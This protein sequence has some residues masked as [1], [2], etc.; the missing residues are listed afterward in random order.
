MAKRF[1]DT[2]IFKKQFIRTLKA[3]YKVLWIY[4]LTDCNHSG[5]WEADF[6][7]AQLRL[8]VKVTKQEAE[9]VFGDKIIVLDNGGKWFIPSFIDF[10]YGKLSA[11]NRAHNSVILLLTKYNLLDEDLSIKE[12]TKPLTSPLQGDM[13][14]DKEKEKDKDKEKDK[15]ITQPKIEKSELELAFDNWVQMRKK[16]KSGITEH[17]IQLGKEEL[18]KL[19][20]GKSETAIAI[21][22]QSILNSWK[23]FF[24]LKTQNNVSTTNRNELDQLLEQSIDTLQ[25]P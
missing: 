24:P 5:I 9:Q 7:V 2:D 21:I 20:G 8:G 17:A 23:G 6:D 25:Q 3:P 13:D 14:M 1:I 22:N 4:V 15:E 16:M 10:Q 11:A 12:L 18:R 19:S